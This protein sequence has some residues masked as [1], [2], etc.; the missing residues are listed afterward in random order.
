[1]SLIA[2]LRQRKVF[3][4][5]AAYAVVAWLLIQVVATVGPALKLPDWTLT[6]T[7]VLLALG[8]PVAL[9]LAWVFDV[10]RTRSGPRDSSATGVA[11]DG[12]AVLPFAN[13]TGEAQQGFLADGI[14]EDVLTRLQATPGLRVVSRQSSHAYQGR[15]VD[16]RTIARELACRY[17]VEGGMRKA[18]DRVRVTV[19]LID[20][21]TDSHVWAERY[22]RRLEDAFQL[23]DEICDHVVAAIQSRVVDAPGVAAQAANVSREPRSHHALPM[24]WAIPALAALVALAALL[25]WTLQKRDEERRAREDLLPRLQALVAADD[26]A[27]AFD[28]ARDIERFTPNDPVLAALRPAFS[29]PVRLNT[30]PEGAKVYYRPYSGKDKDW[31]LLGE[32]PL[33]DVQVPLGVSLWRFEKEGRATAQFVL[34]NPG[35]VLGNHPFSSCAEKKDKAKCVDYL[36]LDKADFTIP[37]ADAATSPPDMVLVPDMPAMIPT[38]GDGS[39]TRLPAFFI[40]RFEVT[41]KAYKEFVAAGGYAEAAYWQDLPLDGAGTTDWRALV[42]RFVDV[43][44]RPGPSNWQAGSYPD[45]TEELPVTGISWFEAAAYCRFRGK[46]LP[47]AYHWYRAANPLQEAWDSLSS[48]IVQQS[49]FS[50]RA[51]RST[52]RM[53]GAGPYGTYDMAGN[54]REWL[55][56]EGSSGRWNVGGTYLDPTYMYAQREVTPPMDRSD[57]NGVRCMRTVQGGPTPEDLRKPIL[58]ENVDFAALQPVGD[59][60]YGILA[61]QL[62]YEPAAALNPTV[63]DLKS[64]SPAWTHQRIELP[65][66]YDDTTFAVDL[67]LPAAGRPP[68]SVIFYMPHAG[69]FSANVTLD[70]F[71]PASEFRL[72]Y[73]LKAGR[74]VAVIAFDGSFQRRWTNARLRASAYEDRYRLWMRHWRQE[75]GR[76]IDYFATR[77]DV[78]A[79]KLGFYGISM[80]SS[81]FSVL[82]AVEKRLGAAVLYSGGIDLFGALPLGEQPFN[83]FPRVTQPVLM[84]NGKFDT[85]FPAASQQRMFDLLGAPPDRKKRVVFEGGHIILPRFQV[86]QLSLDWFDEYLGPAQPRATAAAK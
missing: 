64:S 48:F 18:G 57:L 35:L 79:G 12:I 71:D 82:L 24:R 59:A 28:L 39:F 7:T 1:M 40:D 22:D 44:G 58:A 16:A 27:A 38:V 20:A 9:V 37:L 4:V 32:T 83:Y 15:S 36:F 78:D 46:E 33:I 56:T 11:A 19:Q 10:V 50:G 31:R 8:F 42:P 23:Q 72:G 86:Q 84:L 53:G 66:G 77:P 5:A 80:G 67:F 51:L 41:N 70:D 69:E 60:A 62:A 6:F 45:G 54:A 85:V 25:T 65:T 29:A 47:T 61:E 21:L 55:W 75:L 52:D 34:R 63:T 43:T 73:L 30:K 3:R 17:V 14:V 13:L 49:N 68:Y 76:T 26:Y 74:G 81:R 2:E